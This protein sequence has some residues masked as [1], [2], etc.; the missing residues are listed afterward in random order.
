MIREETVHQV[1]A[2]QEEIIRCAKDP[3]LGVEDICACLHLTRRHADRAFKALTGMTVHAYIRAIRLTDSVAALDHRTVLDTALDAGFETHEGYTRAFAAFFGVTPS[4][5]RRLHP[6]IPLHVCYPVNA[7]FAYLKHQEE[8]PMEDTNL[9]LLIPA[10]KPRRKL[11]LLRAETA[12]DYWSFCREKGCEWLGLMRSIR[13][14]LDEPA[15]VE[16][17]P[18]LLRPGTVPVAAGVDVPLDW[19]EALLPPGYECVQADACDMMEFVTPPFARDEDFCQAL[20]QAFHAAD[21]WQPAR[22]G[23]AWAFDCAPRYNFGADA[24]TGAR[25]SLPVRR[26]GQ[27]APANRA[28]P[29]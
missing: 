4:Q 14:R 29:R 18:H 15:L 11:V 26:V 17:P 22:Y 20:S 2:L 9:C 21:A 7:R 5:Y 1:Q 12:T 27:S 6:P 13:T 25:L 10:A 8:S 3:A 24:A 23:W 16:L 28:I 19:D